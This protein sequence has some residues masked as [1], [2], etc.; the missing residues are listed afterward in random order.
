MIA[1]ELRDPAEVGHGLAEDVEHVEA[2]AAPNARRKKVEA[3]TPH[4]ALVPI[5]QHFGLDAGIG[6]GDAA[7]PL[8]KALQ[9][10]E[11][12]AIVVD[13]G[14]ALHHEAIAEAEVIQQ[15]DQ[16]LDRRVGRRVGAARL[17]GEFVGRPEN[18]EVGV[19]GARRR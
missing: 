3:Q 1:E 4:A 17:V 14:V 10:I 8:R 7:Q 12:D 13:V 9:R 18:V 16:A 19:P 11:H 5:A 6:D 2:D 15:R